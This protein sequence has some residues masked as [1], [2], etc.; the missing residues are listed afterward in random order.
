LDRALK[1]NRDVG[2]PLPEDVLVEVR[3]DAAIPD[4]LRSALMSGF[5]GDLQAVDTVYRTKGVLA[6]G[7]LAS[8]FAQS[9]AE[10][11]LLRERFEAVALDALTQT[12][13]RALLVEET[14]KVALHPDAAPFHRMGAS[15]P[16]QYLVSAYADLDAARHAQIALVD[17]PDVSTDAESAFVIDLPGHQAGYRTGWSIMHH[18]EVMSSEG[19]L[20]SLHGSAK[21]AVLSSGTIDFD[22]VV[23]ASVKQTS[24]YVLAPSGA[25]KGAIDHLALLD[26]TSTRW[27]EP[28]P[29]ERAVGLPLAECSDDQ[30]W[31]VVSRL[32]D[33]GRSQ[34]KQSSLLQI[35]ERSEGNQK[36]QAAFVERVSATFP[37]EIIRVAI[38]RT[39]AVLARHATDACDLYKPALSETFERIPWDG[40]S[41]GAFGLSADGRFRIGGPPPSTYDVD[42]SSDSGSS[43]F[44][45]DASSDVSSIQGDLQH[46]D[47]TVQE[48]DAQWLLACPDRTGDFGKPPCVAL[49]PFHAIIAVVYA[50]EMIA[51]FELTESE[52]VGNRGAGAEPLPARAVRTAQCL[53]HLARPKGY[54]WLGSGYVATAPVFDPQKGLVLHAVT[55]DYAYPQQVVIGDVARS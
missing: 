33:D 27:V 54:E 46:L 44:S 11:P 14:G 17:M 53:H 25:H 52:T 21:R 49:F 41:G 55:R 48:G 10:H 40:D 19:H 39:G 34:A 22:T 31:L 23:Q 15:W 1:H 35:Y 5:P 45:D 29:L 37:G 51:F 13:G 42:S 24:P 6:V 20:L 4:T 30:R 32:S 38:T 28:A 26:G 3:S 50:D 36:N 12:E 47:V 7:E 9:L 43:S 18:S 8:L 2:G 16:L